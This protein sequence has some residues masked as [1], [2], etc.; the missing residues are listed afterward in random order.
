MVVE[1]FLFL[2]F[3]ELILS[4]LDRFPIKLIVNSKQVSFC[5]DIKKWNVLHDIVE[6]HC[7]GQS[8]DRCTIN[9]VFP[10]Q[11]GINR[12]L[13]YDF[14]IM[15]VGLLT[16]IITYICILTNYLFEP[17]FFLFF[18][19]SSD[20][21]LS[22]I[23]D[24]QSKSPLFIWICYYL[25]SWSLGIVLDYINYALIFIF[26]FLFFFFVNYYKFFMFFY[27]FSI[28]AFLFKTINIINIYNFFELW[29]RAYW[30]K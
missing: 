12:I 9:L 26:S 8:Y 14:I 20:I 19:A 7:V 2:T 30:H 6:S 24:S 11:I 16:I 29:S 28:C 3:L 18:S 25:E 23:M 5:F 1:F 17:T 13:L 4:I 27:R 21:K 10:V 22:I 15:A